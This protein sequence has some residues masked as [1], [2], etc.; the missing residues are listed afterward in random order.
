VAS[1]R[2]ICWIADASQALAEFAVWCAGEAVQSQGADSVAVATAR[3]AAQY[4]HLNPVTS[5]TIASLSHRIAAGSASPTF[6]E[7]R[8]TIW[9]QQNAQLEALLLNCQL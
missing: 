4:A 5:A 3:A 9:S 6:W 2:E 1:W 8:N 7:T